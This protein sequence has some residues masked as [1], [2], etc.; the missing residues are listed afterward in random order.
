MSRIKHRIF[1]KNR[2]EFLETLTVADIKNLQPQS[3]CLSVILNENAGIIDDCIIT[4][5]NDHL[6]N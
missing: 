1:G 4:N 3:S 6:Y 2:F 5:M